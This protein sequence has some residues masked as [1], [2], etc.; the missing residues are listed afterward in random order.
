MTS[1]IVAY[2]GAKRNVLPEAARPLAL[3]APLLLLLLFS[4]AVPIAMLMSRAVYEPTIANALPQTAAALRES[5]AAGVPDEAVFRAFAA[6]LKDAQAAGT[7]YEFAKSLNAR[8]SGVRSQVLRIARNA[9]QDPALNKD[10][11]IQ[12][13]PLLGQA[14][15]W[16]VVRAGTNR[17]TS[18]YLLNAFDLH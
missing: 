18:F 6:D 7:V 15:T 14:Q 13:A 1:A 10:R 5:S 4:F 8:L 17:F 2:A 11:M 12:A 9:A 16:S 3:A